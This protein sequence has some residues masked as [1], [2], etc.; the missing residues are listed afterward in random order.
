[1]LDARAR[2]P[3]GSKLVSDD[4]A[5][6]T[7]I[8]V[9]ESASKKR[10]D[11]LARQVIV[12]VA[13]EKKSKHA[14]SN[15]GRAEIDL[16]WFLKQLGSEDVTHLLVEGGGEINASFLRQGLAHRIVFFYA[17]KIIGGREAR[18]AVAGNGVKN[19]NNA[20]RLREVEWRKLGADLL[21]TARVS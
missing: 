5:A 7:T 13:P 11:V 2:T 20:I 1:V 6:L 9:G 18:K 12:W 19:M 3:L 8:V 14:N 16:R 21:L 17:P 4:F 10:V 15:P